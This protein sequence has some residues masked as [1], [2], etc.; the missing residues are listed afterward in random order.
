M[1][2][3]AECVASATQTAAGQPLTVCLG[4]GAAEGTRGASE[5]IWPNGCRKRTH[6]SANLE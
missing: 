1:A 3:V 4:R 5:L 6:T 2:L